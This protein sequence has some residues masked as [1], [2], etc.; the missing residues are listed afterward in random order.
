MV[1]IKQ[2]RYFMQKEE[3]EDCL[4]TAD[5]TEMDDF[6]SL[7]AGVSDDIVVKVEQTDDEEEEED[8]LQKPGQMDNYQQDQEDQQIPFYEQHNRVGRLHLTREGFT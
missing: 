5:L 7:L 3:P 8:D 2:E 4:L 6:D 1:N